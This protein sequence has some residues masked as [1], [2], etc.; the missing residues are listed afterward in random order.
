MLNVLLLVS[1]RAETHILIH[2]IPKP[3]ATHQKKKFK[4]L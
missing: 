4:F 1:D 2:M 3:V